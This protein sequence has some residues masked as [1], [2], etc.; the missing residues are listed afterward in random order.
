MI[1]TLEELK[2]FI[3]VNGAELYDRT[4]RFTI[5]FGLPCD[6][7]A[8][9]HLSSNGI[10]F[11]TINCFSW[12]QTIDIRR[13]FSYGDNHRSRALNWLDTVKVLNDTIHLIEREVNWHED[14]N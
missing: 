3:D 5:Q 6:G 11:E 1:K 8:M 7:N 9:V 13:R 2:L 10:A 12:N 14:T 4:P